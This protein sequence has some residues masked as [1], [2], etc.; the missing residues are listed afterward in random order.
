MHRVLVPTDFTEAGMLVTGEAMAWVEAMG[1]EVM[2]LHVVPDLFIRWLDHLS[3]TFIDHTRLESAYE[4][5]RAEGRR[6]FA[7]WLPSSVT[8]HCRT[9][10]VVGDTADAIL[11]VAQAAEV[12][13]IVMRAPRRRWW[14]PVLAG[15]VTD[16]VMRRAPVPVVVW[17]GLDYMPAG[18]CWGGTR[19]PHDDEAFREGAWQE[20]QQVRWQRTPG[21][22]RW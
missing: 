11:E 3:T 1:G 10:V 2:L 8:E 19:R 20:R 17:A 21:R 13:V 5:L 7:A 15:S 4:D 14:R 9:H 18:G 16:T 6:K 22:D 12:D